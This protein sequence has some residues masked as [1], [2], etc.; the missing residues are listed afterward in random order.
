MSL[1][2]DFLGIVYNTFTPIFLIAGAAVLLGRKFEIDARTLSRVNIYLFVPSLILNSLL[3]TEMSAGEIGRVFATVVTC[4]F[5]MAAAAYGIGKLIRL[6]R[7][8]HSTFVLTSIAMNGLNFGLPFIEFSF[9]IEA[10]DRSIV[11]NIGQILM[12]YTLGIFVISSGSLSLK[13]SLGNVFRVPLPYVFVIGILSNVVGVTLPVPLLKSV[14]VLGNAAVPCALIILGLQLGRA[15]LKG[16]WKPILTVTGMRFLL[17]PLLIFAI[18]GLYGLSGLTREVLILQYSMPVGV[19]S[20]VLATE[21]DGDTDYAAAAI[22]FT[23]LF[24]VIP[25]SILLFLR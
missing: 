10:I 4:A 17:A 22:F 5:V 8:L 21:F 12:V 7:K 14:G 19:V 16:R 18:T 2:A 25:L 20:A 6:P 11:F 3:T 23:T 15:T 13:D 24:S 1:L 9:G